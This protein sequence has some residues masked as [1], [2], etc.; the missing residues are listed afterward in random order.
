MSFENRSES[1]EP[2]IYGQVLLECGAA[3]GATQLLAALIVS[4]SA[5]AAQQDFWIS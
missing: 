5:E 3:L 4:L 1:A 2:R